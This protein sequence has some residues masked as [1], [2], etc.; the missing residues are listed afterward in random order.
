[1]DVQVNPTGLGS[2]PQPG[3]TQEIDGRQTQSSKRLL[4]PVR[5]LSLFVRVPL[6]DVMVFES[7]PRQDLL[8][9][10]KLVN[11]DTSAVLAAKY[12]HNRRACHD[13]DKRHTRILICVMF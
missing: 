12:M 5:V 8:A 1:M 10:V 9:G 4:A 6:S 3:P 7:R 2:L 11:A 13:I